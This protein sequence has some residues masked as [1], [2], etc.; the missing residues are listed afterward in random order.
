MTHW[1]DLPTE[2][3]QLIRDYVIQDRLFSTEQ[4][5]QSIADLATVNK[6]WQSEVEKVT[7]KSLCLAFGDYDGGQEIFATRENG[8]IHHARVALATVLN[9][10][11]MKYLRELTIQFQFPGS[12]ASIGTDNV[13]Y[14]CMATVHQLCSILSILH[15]VECPNT[16]KQFRTL[17]IDLVPVV[18][19]STMSIN[20]LIWPGPVSDHLINRLVSVISETPKVAAV[21]SLSLCLDSLPPP[22]SLQLIGRFPNLQQID[23]TLSFDPS[24]I[25]VWKAL[26]DIIK[27]GLPSAGPKLSSIKFSHNCSPSDLGILSW[28]YNILLHQYALV[29]PF[30]N[31]LLEYSCQLQRLEIGNLAI[32]HELNADIFLM[33]TMF[34]V[35]SLKIPQSSNVNICNVRET[36][37][38]EI[39]GMGNRFVVTDAWKHV[40]QARGLLLDIRW[41]S[42]P[43]LHDSIVDH[44]QGS[45]EVD[46]DG[47]DGDG[48]VEDYF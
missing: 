44:S 11:R 25:H 7:F 4:D 3:R 48:E 46:G 29:Q 38:L 12:P 37:T 21:T 27:F 42:I 19:G 33:A 26:A 6:E 30:V 28:Q 40:A 31:A 9:S 35:N 17:E 45:E 23:S 32:S 36:A 47:E 10:R 34:Q 8:S 5:P 43:M 15:N 20:S 22:I 39:C 2:L 14:V 18:F 24:E 13:A 41:H 1:V 16:D